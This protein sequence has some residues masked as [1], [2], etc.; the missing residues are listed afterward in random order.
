MRGLILGLLLVAVPADEL[1]RLLSLVKPEPMTGLA[2]DER[3]NLLVG[4]PVEGVVFHPSEPPDGIS[5]RCRESAQFAAT[6]GAEAV[7]CIE[8]DRLRRLVDPEEPE[9]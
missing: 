6:L 2:I 1:D 3:G 5:T 4:A 7:V 9:P 8:D